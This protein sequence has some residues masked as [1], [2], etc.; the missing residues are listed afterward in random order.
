M[1][2]DF[3]IDTITLLEEVTSTQDIAKTLAESGSGAQN[4]LVQARAQNAGRGRYERRWSSSKGGLYISLLLHPHKEAQNI[5]RLSVKTGEAVAKT[6][7]QL[8]GIKTKIKLPNDVLAFHGG[9]YKKIAGILIESSSGQ[10]D[11]NWLVIGV[12][13]NLNNALPGKLEAIS[14][15]KIISKPVNIEEFRDNFLKNFAENYLIWQASL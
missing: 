3:N 4:A 5:L 2:L 7:K 12:G 9:N 1:K 14:V 8:Y 6:L 13:V 11:L 15:K 10:N